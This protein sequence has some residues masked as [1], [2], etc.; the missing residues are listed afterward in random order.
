MN[1]RYLRGL[2]LIVLGALLYLNNLGYD[3]NLDKNLSSLV[4]N[5]WPIVIIVVGIAL[6]LKK[7]SFPGYLIS[8]FGILLILKNYEIVTISFGRIIRVY[9]G[10]AIVFMGYKKVK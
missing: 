8:I 7:K 5:V 1:Y 10:L 4:D 6:I 3:L 9:I 2:V